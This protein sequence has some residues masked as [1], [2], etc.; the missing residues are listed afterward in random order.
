MMRVCIPDAPL[1]LLFSFS[2]PSSLPF[3]TA[4]RESLGGGRGIGPSERV[5]VLQ[6]LGWPA[7]CQVAWP[8]RVSQLLPQ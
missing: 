5:L 7:E 3:L 1:F 8:H 6:L 4:D 2:L